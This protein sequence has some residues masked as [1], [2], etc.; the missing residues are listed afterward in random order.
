MRNEWRFPKDLENSLFHFIFYTSTTS[1]TL[2]FFW[3]FF[4]FFF[5]LLIWKLLATLTASN[6]IA[7]SFHWKFNCIDP[8]ISWH[9]YGILYVYF[10]MALPFALIFPL[11]NISTRINIEQKPGE[12]TW[13]TENV[14]ENSWWWCTKK[15]IFFCFF[16][17]FFFCVFF[18]LFYFLQ[19]LSIISK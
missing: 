12:H 6:C 19:T 5:L 1:R 9:R 8:R 13:T 18:L 14:S 3:F 11:T 7:K 4:F 15:L 17:V 10:W 2:W 16:F